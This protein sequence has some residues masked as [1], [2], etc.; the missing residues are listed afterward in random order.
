MALL[1]SP[2]TSTATHAPYD[3]PQCTSER[4]FCSFCNVRI[5]RKIAFGRSLDFSNGK[6]VGCIELELPSNKEEIAVHRKI[7]I[8]LRLPF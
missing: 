7:G 2:P 5:Y 6:L 4:A 1:P 8:P 3:H